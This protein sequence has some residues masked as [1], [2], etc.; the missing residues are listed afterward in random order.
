MSLGVAEGGAETFGDPGDLVAC[1]ESP[2]PPACSSKKHWD[3]TEAVLVAPVGCVMKR[4]FE[5]FIFRDAVR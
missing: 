2:Q 4:S 1:E 3:E 5:C